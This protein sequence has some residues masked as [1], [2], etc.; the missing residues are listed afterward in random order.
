VL[1]I[2]ELASERRAAAAAQYA[3]AKRNLD[4]ADSDLQEASS[5]LSA[6]EAG[7]GIPAYE[8]AERATVATCRIHNCTVHTNADK[9]N[10]HR[11]A[12]GVYADEEP[13]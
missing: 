9:N 1:A 12:V 13:F 11:L 4:R 6:H 2:W 3:A 7:P 5:S 8:H 10:A